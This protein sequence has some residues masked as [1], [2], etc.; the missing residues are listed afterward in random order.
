[1]SDSIPTLWHI[2]ISHFSEKARWALAYKGVKHKR[3]AVQPGAHIPTALVLTRGAHN[4][5]PVLILDGR[6]IGDSTEV[7]AA[8]ERS[9]PDPPLYPSDPADRERAL[10]LEDFFD[11]ELGPHVRHLCFHELHKDSER[12]EALIRRTAPP[13]LAKVPAAAAVY[14]RTFARLRWNARDEREAEVAREKIVAAFD[15][16]DEELAAGGGDYLVGASFSVADL[17]AASLLNPLVLPEDGPLPS[18]EPPPRGL[19]EF[20]APLEERPGFKWV[21]E[22]YRRHRKPAAV[23]A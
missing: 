9:Y 22:M 20:L 10:E 4:T 19:A 6:S 23:A 16:L 13:P 1:M 17:T 15:R 11:E 3:R 5:F 2:D 12:L 21:D 18:D 7:I 8:L 14:A